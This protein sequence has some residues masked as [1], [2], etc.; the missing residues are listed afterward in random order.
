M[1]GIT[2]TDEAV[3]KALSYLKNHENVAKHA[4]ARAAVVWAEE[5]V[6]VVR[7]EQF[8]NADPSKSAAEREQIARASDAHKEA[9]QTWRDCVE[10]DQKNREVVSTACLILDLYRT[11]SANARKTYI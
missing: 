4:A 6:K 7:A 8:L 9:L 2:I 3:E 10:Q 5:N 1:T 11:V